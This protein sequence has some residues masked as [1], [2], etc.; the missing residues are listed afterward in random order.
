MF[1]D[2]DEFCRSLLLRRPSVA[3]VTWEDPG[4]LESFLKRLGPALRREAAAVTLSKLPCAD[5][6]GAS[7]QQRIVKSLRRPSAAQ[8]CLLIYRIEP[9]AVAAATVLNGFRERLASYAAVIVVIRENRRRDFVVA[10]PDLMDWVGTSV[11]RAEDLA[12]PLTLRDVNATIRRFEE[13]FGMSTRDFQDKWQRGEIQPSDDHW[14]WNTLI[15]IRDGMK[16]G[17]S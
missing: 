1:L 9:L 14:F 5:L 8:R 12:P 10:C 15:A 4:A 6:D 17:S 7:F 11:T 16:S 13:Q 3:L 2:L